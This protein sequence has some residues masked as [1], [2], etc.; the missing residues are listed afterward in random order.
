MRISLYRF[1][2]DGLGHHP[3]HLEK[4]AISK[5]TYTQKIGFQF[6]NQ[7]HVFIGHI[8]GVVTI[9]ILENHVRLKK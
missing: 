8:L 3:Q 7:A 2:V 1:V 6:T 9:E 4:Y 5:D